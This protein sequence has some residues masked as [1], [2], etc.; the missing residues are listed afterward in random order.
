MKMSKIKHPLIKS[1]GAKGSIVKGR[2]A[3]SA[4]AKDQP[5]P[6]HNKFWEEMIIKYLILTRYSD[7]ALFGLVSDAYH[8]F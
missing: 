8:G 6:S 5:Q 2:N 3:Y 4:R 1:V 7:F